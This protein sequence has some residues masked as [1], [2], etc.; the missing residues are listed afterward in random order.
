MSTEYVELREEDYFVAGSRVTI[1]CVV[2][3]YLGGESA[4]T[5]QDNFPALTLEEI[6]GAIAY[7]LRHRADI[8]KYLEEKHAAFEEARRT[9]H[10][11]DELRARL[12][13]GRQNLVRR[14]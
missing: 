7:Y 2:Y 1:D 3:G 13:L 4:E 8:D 12:A 5:I 9:Q 14:L 11:P 6:H 10:I